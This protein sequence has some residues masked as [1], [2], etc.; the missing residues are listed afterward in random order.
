MMPFSGGFEGIETVRTRFRGGGGRL[1][2]FNG[3][4][5]TV[6]FCS[7]KTSDRKQ[8]RFLVEGECLLAI[9]VDGE[10]GNA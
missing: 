5:L 9:K 3:L 6:E 1:Y 2:I 7:N 10:S 4:V 8:L